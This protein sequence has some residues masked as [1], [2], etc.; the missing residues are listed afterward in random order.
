[1]AGAQ[2]IGHRGVNLMSNEEAGEIIRE[3]QRGRRGR[4]LLKVAL[5]ATA[6]AL[7][8]GAAV[9]VGAIP[10][11]DNVI[12]AC[13]NTISGGTVEIVQNANAT[14]NVPSQGLLR[15]I[16][17]SLSPTLPSGGLNPAAACD[18]ETEAAISW[19]QDGPTGPTGPA[20]PAG[21][22]GAAGSNGAPGAAGGSGTPG[23]QGAPGS[24]L[25]GSSEFGIQGAGQVFAKFTGIT[26]DATDK[27][28]KGDIVLESASIGASAAAS[29][30]GAGGRSS[31]QTFTITK[32]VDKASPLLFEAAASGKAIKEA[33]I[34][35]AK[36]KGG[37]EQDYLEFKLSEVTVVSITDG[38]SADTG[39]PVEA[40]KL[41]FAHLSESY[42]VNHKVATTVQ[43]TP[44][45]LK[46]L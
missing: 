28:H 1:M 16:D 41:S 27:D 36:G 22:K 35:F 20:G 42:L 4:G 12:H 5:P 29:T 13:Y 8:A 38:T 40:V 23:A 10:G 33:D 45:T 26:G 9:A 6:A 19:N 31:V 34:F 7:G 43:L 11:S 15:V 25:L 39:T 3:A 18:P 21:A 37:T 32:R 17:P 46:G 2:I 44:I 24:S 14:I 30:G